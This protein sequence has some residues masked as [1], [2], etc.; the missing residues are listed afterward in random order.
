MIEASGPESIDAR[1]AAGKLL[2]ARRT[3]RAPVA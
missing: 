3:R 1:A 2:P